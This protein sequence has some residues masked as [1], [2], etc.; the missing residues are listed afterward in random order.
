MLA[1]GSDEHSVQITLVAEFLDLVQPFQAV[2]EAILVGAVVSDHDKVG[3][4]AHAHGDG[5]VKL[6]PAEIEK[7][8]LDAEI[9]FGEGNDLGVDFCTLGLANRCT[10]IL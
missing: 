5:L 10:T 6:M 9:L 2:F 1:F 4:F 3:I 7:E 8:E